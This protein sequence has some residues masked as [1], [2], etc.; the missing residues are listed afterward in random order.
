M[1]RPKE[2]VEEKMADTILI[3]KIKEILSSDAKK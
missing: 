1:E 3:E 2:S